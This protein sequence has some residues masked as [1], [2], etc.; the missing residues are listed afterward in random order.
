MNRKFI[1]VFFILSLCF[2]WAHAQHMFSIATDLSLLKSIKKDQR[3]FNAGQNI[4]S[5]FN[6]SEKDGAY[7]SLAY[8][9][10][11]NFKNNLNAKAKS[12][13]TNPQNIAFENEAAMKLKQL[14]IGFKHYVKGTADA[15]GNWNLYGTAGFG[16]LIGSIE[17]SYSTNIDTSKYSLPSNPVA[18]KGNFKRLT[19]DLGLGAELPLGAGIFLYTEGRTW[20]PSSSYP[21]TYLFVNDKAPFILTANFGIRVL[22]H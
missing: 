3:F 19:L 1:I 7:V 16:L 5:H 6:Y 22:F 18:G 17:N 9:A 13:N 20:I 15:E 21:S 2:Q 14:S 11:G 4:V 10:T 8:Y 12:S